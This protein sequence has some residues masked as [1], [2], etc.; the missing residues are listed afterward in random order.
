ML[1]WYPPIKQPIEV[2]YIIQ[3]IG[4]RDIWQ[5][6]LTFHVKSFLQSDGFPVDFPPI[7][8]W[9]QWFPFNHP[10]PAALRALFNA[11]RLCFGR[12]LRPLAMQRHNVGS[13]LPP[14]M[15]AGLWA[16]RRRWGPMGALKA[17][18]VGLG[19][20]WWFHFGSPKRLRNPGWMNLS[21]QKLTI[22][23]GCRIVIS[24][25]DNLISRGYQEYQIDITRN[26]IMAGWGPL[27]D[28]HPLVARMWMLPWA[29]LICW[30][31]NELFWAAQS[32]RYS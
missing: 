14:A 11:A 18:I 21:A 26:R 17:A 8:P 32:A 31:E 16:R 23:W 5:E 7:H 12:S 13:E 28:R 1:E 9:F 20:S 19:P 29:H 3:W 22:I 6:T 2:Y 30:R 25:T 10:D 4:S 24:G 27:S 15:R